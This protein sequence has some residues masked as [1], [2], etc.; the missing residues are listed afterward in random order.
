MRQTDLIVDISQAF[1]I[2][3][4][5]VELLAGVGM[6][7]VNDKVIVHMVAVKMKRNHNA[8]SRPRATG[9]LQAHLD[10]FLGIDVLVGVEGLHVVSEAQSV[11]LLPY[12]FIRHEL[13][14]RHFGIAAQARHA[15][16]LVG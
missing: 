13:L 12:G 2:V 5:L 4:V 11:G 7:R 8:I 10:H 9:E 15:P 3:S 6:H 1:D 14:I 16:S